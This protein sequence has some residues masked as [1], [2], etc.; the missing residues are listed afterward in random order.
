MPTMAPSSA[1]DATDR[2]DGCGAQAYVRVVLPG[3]GE[4]HFC[5]HHWNRH[6]DSLRA[7]AVDITDETHRIADPALEP[8][9]SDH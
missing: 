6:G 3:G 2:C 5:G 1:L 4:L 9:P 8:A 7:Q